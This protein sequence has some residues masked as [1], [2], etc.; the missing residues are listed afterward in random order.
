VSDQLAYDVALVMLAVE[1][2]IDVELDGFDRPQ[3]GRSRLEEALAARGI[4]IDE[5]EDQ[6]MSPGRS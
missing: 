5:A 2:G 4:P 6:P 1:H 3:L